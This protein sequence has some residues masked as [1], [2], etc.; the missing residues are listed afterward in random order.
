MYILL[1][2]AG[3]SSLKAVLM[4]SATGS[5][6]SRGLAD[7]AGATTCYRFAKG[8]GKEQAENASWRGHAKAVERFVADLAPD[9]EL[10]QVA[11]QASLD[12]GDGIEL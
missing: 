4:D 8:D 2:N 1:L 6:V 3:S 7:W 12:P 11:R 10:R 5:V 9:R